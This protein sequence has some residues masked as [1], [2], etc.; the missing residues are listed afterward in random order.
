MPDH[1]KMPVTVYQI[2]LFPFG[3]DEPA[4][5][6]DRIVKRMNKDGG[7]YMEQ[8]VSGIIPKEFDVR[9]YASFKIFPPRWRAFLS[10]VIDRQ[11]S[12]A[13]CENLSNSFV[14]FIVYEKQIFAIAGGQGSFAIDAF[15]SQNFGLEILVRLFEKNSKVIKSI[16]DRGV[17]GIVL[18]QTKSYRGDQRF[19]DEN[20]FGK[21]FK[22]VRAE[23][24]KRIL[25]K[26]FG[27][28]EG[29]LKR[30]VSGCQAKSSF[31]INKAIDFDTLLLLI[32]RFA[33]ILKLPEKFSLNKV[34]L[35]S[36]RNP[37]NVKLISE[38]N[39]H[40]IEKIYDDHKNGLIPDVDFCHKEFEVYLTASLFFI[41]LDRNEW[42][43]LH[44]PPSLA[45]VILELQNTGRCLDDDAFQ[46]KESVLYRMLTTKDE[47]NR[48]LTSDTVLDHIH[49]EITHKDN[50]YFIVDGEWYQIHPE[51]ILE[52]NKE[53]TEILKQVWDDNLMTDPF[54]IN[55]RESIFNMQYLGKE[56]WLVLDTITPDNI[57]CCDLLKHDKNDVHLVHVKKGFDN[58]VRD[59]ASQVLIAAK[60]LREDMKS[61]YNY[62]DQ[63]EQ[64]TKKGFKSES[65]T[66]KKMAGQIFPAG[67]LKRL[68][69]D[70]KDKNIIFCLAFVDTACAVRSLKNNVDRFQ[71]NIAKYSLVEL[72]REIMS[73][74]FGF[75]VIQ[76]NKQ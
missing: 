20:Q 47:E 40:L 35:I 51:F 38:L 37:T 22:Q 7:G 25:T 16:Q 33:E 50:V 44:N 76:L 27:F 13:D 29:D 5:I 46:F 8:Q 63:V 72:R 75:K 61:G 48:F 56:G 21:I 2:D 68:F 17:T 60:R 36:K 9:M 3:D 39:E 30:T 70:R 12:L 41:S 59:L 31:Q 69:I 14:C 4:V 65:I 42:I 11:S 28:S 10:P 24:S 66:V 19:S 58:S 32:K 26:T 74:G 15:T 64:Q 18:G 73:M 53:C 23:L 43:E 54:D 52:L 67:G 57:E 34:T 1:E 49:G 71:S 55:K 6:I 45:E 62:I